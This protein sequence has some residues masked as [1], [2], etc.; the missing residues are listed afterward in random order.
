MDADGVVGSNNQALRNKGEYLTMALAQTDDILD[1]ITRIPV[2]PGVGL[3][4]LRML[5]DK[6]VSAESL[7]KV[8]ERDPSLSARLIKMANS[9]FYGLAEPVVSAWRSV[10]VIGVATVRSVVAAAALD[11]GTAEGVSVPAGFWTHATATAA[12]AGVLAEVADLNAGDAFSIGLLH[13]IGLALVFRKVPE[14]FAALTASVGEGVE[15]CEAERVRFGADHAEIG[16]RALEALRFGAESI[17]AV[18]QH[19]ESNDHSALGLVLRGADEL[20]ASILGE[21]LAESTR[22]LDAVLAPLNMTS[23]KRTEVVER[24]TELCDELSGLMIG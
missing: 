12:A 5:D 16:A 14:E 23:M 11:L 24:V 22:D 15:L 1:E 7:G 10:T 20:A 8:L 21:P 3:R 13:D 17:M 4:L 2:Q 9:S 18:R 19:H 6:R